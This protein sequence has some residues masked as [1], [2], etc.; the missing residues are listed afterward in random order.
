MSKQHWKDG[1]WAF[2]TCNASVWPGASKY[3]VKT[4]AD[5]LAV[6]ETKIPNTEC[7]DAEQT[8]RNSGWRTAIGPRMVTVVDGKLAGIA[9]SG[10]THI[11]MKSPI[12]TEAWPKL[13]DER[14]FLEHVAAICNGGVHAGSCYLTSCNPGSATQGI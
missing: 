2:D 1:L 3:L 10:R 11:G 13:L 6:Q 7:S 5:F 4:Q 14:F 12:C 9:I 8:A